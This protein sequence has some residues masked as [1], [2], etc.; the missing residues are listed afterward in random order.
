MAQ[1]G[2]SVYSPHTAVDAVPNGMADWLCDVVTTPEMGVRSGGPGNDESRFPS[3]LGDQQTLPLHDNNKPPLPPRD[4]TR[5]Q[6]ATAVLPHTRSTILLNPSPP[7]GFESAGMGRLLTLATP[8][9]LTSLVMRIAKATED[10]VGIPVARP[11]GRSIEEITIRTVATCPGSGSSI[12]MQ[13]GRPVADLL[14]TGELSHHEALAAI[15]YGSVVIS[16]F[17]S[18]SER[19]YLRDVMQ[20]KLQDDLEAE[21]DIVRSETA[22]SLDVDDSVLKELLNDETF[23]VDVSRRDRDPY[24]VIALS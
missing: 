10:A 20:P 5:S 12:L 15:E 9:P 19:G 4:S 16:L 13:N 14:I 6:A 3:T 7:P 11:Q 21:W 23:Q 24:E 2:I 1:E 18:N 17:H 8:E 22:S